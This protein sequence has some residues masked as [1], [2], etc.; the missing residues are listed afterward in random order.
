MTVY[1]NENDRNTAAWLRELI[2]AGRIAPG[3]V[4][5]RSIEDVLPIELAGYTQCHF[6]AG[7]GVLS[8]ALRQAGWPD[9][10]PVWTGSCPCQGLSAAGK[11]KGFAD[12]RHLWPHWFHLIQHAKP[13]DTPIMG[14]QVASPLALEWLDLVQTDMEATGATFRAVDLCAAGFGAPHIRQRLFWMAYATKLGRI[15]GRTGETSHQ[16]RT[17]K[18]LERFR[19][20]S[21]VG[22]SVGA[23]PQG[24]AGHGHNTAGRSVAAGSVTETGRNGRLAYSN[25]N[26][27][28]K[29]EREP[30][31]QAEEEAD[32]SAIDSGPIGGLDNT[33]GRDAGAERKQCRG[34]HRQLQKDASTCDRNGGAHPTNGFW[35]DV[36]WLG[37]RD[38]KFRPVEPGTFPLV[39][40]APARVV[41]LRGYGNAIPAEVAQAFIET[42]MVDLPEWRAG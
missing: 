29:H 28:S 30:G 5:E 27:G 16:P 21:G 40:G 19:D 9:D 17:L 42:M 36:D 18:R 14:E 12:E 25:S 1:Y 3:Y 34:E 8:Y 24:H 6:F 38:G 37:C 11:G 41:R 20:A 39:N 33:D 23:G 35:G 26:A 31:R 4:D 15:G 22:N 7:I 32:N 10:R 13:A 2:K